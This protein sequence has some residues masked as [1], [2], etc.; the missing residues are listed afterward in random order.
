[1]QGFFLVVQTT[2]TTTSLPKSAVSS[3]TVPEQKNSEFID[4]NWRFPAAPA[5]P[6]ARPPPRGVHGVTLKSLTMAV[7][8]ARKR[9]GMS[10]RTP[11]SLGDVAWMLADPSIGF[12]E[13][14]GVLLETCRAFATDERLLSRLARTIFVRKDHMS[15]TSKRTR[16]QYA[17]ISGNL[18]RVQQLLALGAP[19][20]AP[21]PAD[22]SDI[23]DYKKYH[24]CLHLSASPL[25]WAVFVGHTAIAHM[26]LAAGAQSGVAIHAIN[27]NDLETLAADTDASVTVNA[28]AQTQLLLELAQYDSAASPCLLLQ[29]GITLRNT[30]IVERYISAAFALWRSGDSRDFD[31]ATWCIY[32]KIYSGWS[33]NPL[34]RADFHSEGPDHVAVARLY[35]AQLLMGDEHLCLKLG[36]AGQFG[37]EA[38]VRE[39]VNNP[40][41][42][43]YPNEALFAV[44][45][46]GVFD[47]FMPLYDR[48]P[49]HF[50]DDE[51]P[52]GENNPSFL[53]AAERG[54]VDILRWHFDHCD[55]ASLPQKELNIDLLAA[56]HAGFVDDVKWLI[57]H[58]ADVNSDVFR[59]SDRGLSES[60]LT[61]ACFRADV[62]MV[63]VLLAAGAHVVFGPGPC[64]ENQHHCLRV[65]VRN[66]DG[67][68][69]GMYAPPYNRPPPS[70]AEETRRVDIVRQLVAAGADADAAE[71]A[72]HPLFL[73]AFPPAVPLARMARLCRGRGCA[74]H[75]TDGTVSMREAVALLAPI[76]TT[77]VRKLK[78]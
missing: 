17:A 59:H 1:M 48:A 9:P 30:Q 47:L 18:V 12:G 54:H 67:A 36:L 37:D 3:S 31:R 24:D 39:L 20:D 65:A 56:V 68:A 22:A 66:D 16:L 15:F 46:A 62:D 21:A 70:P 69:V 40:E 42:C 49:S 58:G 7:Q 29:V 73:R 8:S 55:R 77:R 71:V 51:F 28:A 14:V 64:A 6:P 32:E 43:P 76:M 23:H 44:C 38:W 60:C 25:A 57:G 41:T 11:T 34:F 35:F 45:S 2:G 74:T 5:G 52:W 78:R 10:Q 19:V 63:S 61:V 13:E 75:G 26:L 4:L 33:G 53:L 72:T 27:Q 50:E